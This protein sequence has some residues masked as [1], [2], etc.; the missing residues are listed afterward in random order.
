MKH[1]LLAAL[2]GA[3]AVGTVMTG[4]GHA[5]DDP[6]YEFKNEYTGKCLAIT[7]TSLGTVGQGACNN[8]LAFFRYYDGSRQLHNEATGKCV[9]VRGRAL[10]AQPCNKAVVQQT[11]WDLF[12]LSNGLTVLMNWQPN[13][14]EHTNVVAW[15]GGNVS[16]EYMDG[17][18]GQDGRK[19]RW[20]WRTV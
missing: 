6:A 13:V 20:W 14:V 18:M 19:L 5:A 16:A 4:T 3:A 15:A 7:N 2:V 1:K 8:P 11:G 9:E 10:T 12:K 17:Y